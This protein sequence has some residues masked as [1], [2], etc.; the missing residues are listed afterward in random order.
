MGKQ[1]VTLADE[2]TNAYMRMVEEI[3]R[4]NFTALDTAGSFEEGGDGS[5]RDMVEGD[6]KDHMDL[7]ELEAAF[8]QVDIILEGVWYIAEGTNNPVL[9]MIV[10]DS[11]T[12]ARAALGRIREFRATYG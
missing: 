1:D 3:V 5:Q 4:E 9:M 12:R 2:G 11:R 7:D 10:T 6:L 8:R